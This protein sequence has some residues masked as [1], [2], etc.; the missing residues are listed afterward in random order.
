M[1][2]AGP[3]GAGSVRRYPLR[4]MNQR[5]ASRVSDARATLR[6]TGKACW[7]TRSDSREQVATRGAWPSTWF[8]N[9]LCDGVNAEQTAAS[10]HPMRHPGE[11]A[12]FAW[13]VRCRLCGGHP[14]ADKLLRL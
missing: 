7:R 12:L 6:E 8:E 11:D 3:A 13:L 14:G 2:N 10:T 9:I 5:L 4:R 1:L